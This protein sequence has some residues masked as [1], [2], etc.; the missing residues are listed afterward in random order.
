MLGRE[1]GEQFVESSGRIKII[2]AFVFRLPVLH[3]K[4][5]IFRHVFGVLFVRSSIIDFE[6][7]VGLQ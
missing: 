3:T 4:S 5:P 1:M 6:Y 7:W 2:V